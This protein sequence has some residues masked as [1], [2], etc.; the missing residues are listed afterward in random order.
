[1]KKL[2][3]FFWYKKFELRPLGGAGSKI[4][5]VSVCYFVS[6]RPIIIPTIAPPLLKSK[7]EIEN[8]LAPHIFGKYAPSI[9]PTKREK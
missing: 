9:E 5:P 2:L 1:M 7:E 8:K 6:L 4:V 3:I